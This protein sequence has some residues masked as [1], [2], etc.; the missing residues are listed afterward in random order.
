MDG[1]GTLPDRASEEQRLE[2]P[3]EV[4][5]LSE[6]V[7]GI[8][9][10]SR[11][12]FNLGQ[13]SRLEEIDQHMRFAKEILEDDLNGYDEVDGQFHRGQAQTKLIELLEHEMP[14]LVVIDWRT[15]PAG[16]DV[17]RTFELPTLEGALFMKVVTGD[18]PV[19]LS[20]QRANLAHSGDPLPANFEVSDAGTTYIL[21][22]FEEIPSDLSR[23]II[24]FTARGETNPRFWSGLS[25]ESPRSGQFSLRVEDENG[26]ATPTL[27]RIT[28]TSTGKLWAPPNAIDLWPTM[29]SVRG[30]PDTGSPQ[31]YMHYFMN[32]SLRGL[33]WIV[34]GPFEMPLPEGEWELYLIKGI[35]YTPVRT[36]F[37]VKAE[38]WT[39]EEIRLKRWV[40]M[41]AKGWYSGDDHVHARMMSSQDAS[42]I[43]AFVKAADIKVANILEMGDPGRTFYEQRGFGPAYRVVDDGYVLVPG[44]E[45]PRSDFG[46]AIGMNLTQL[47]R[48]LDKY[49]LN[50]WV[51]DEIHRQGGLYG[52]THVG[53]GGLG[54]HRDMTLLMPRGKSD[55]ASIM[56]NILGTGRYYDFLN[57][58]FK[59]AASAGSDTPYGGA[60]GITRVYAF[61]GQETPFSADA[62]FDAVKGGHT[63][64]TNGPMLELKVGE[65]MPGDTIV[66][67]QPG[68]VKIRARAW[69]LKEMSAPRSFS[70]VRNG[71]VVKKLHLEHPDQTELSVELDIETGN[72]CWIAVTAEGLDGSQAHTTPVYI[73]RKGFR[74]WNTDEADRLIKERFATLD[75]IEQLV[76]AQSDR[77]ANGTINPLEYG[78]ILIA[79]QAPEIMERTQLVRRLYQELVTELNKELDAGS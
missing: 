8:R 32:M 72:G 70:V 3:A 19:E 68:T 26:Q 24:T 74:H 77:M 51:A 39:R 49:M 54:I 45:D 75:E 59:L 13:L 12:Q 41:P 42:D 1:H 55:F 79:E 21:A 67:D 63:F 29:K 18:G 9:E 14:E 71:V 62:W 56:Q 50:D 5:G 57:L 43:M 31:P 2:I 28:N 7:T 15:G 37:T 66:L 40:D 76:Q 65:S 35:E 33:Y 6:F 36:T 38:E 46:H 30:F 44:Q 60:V 10:H 4:P 25:V 58:G 53:E 73:H 64:V 27:I 61:I 20:V 16:H 47:A 23:L 52:H 78:N 17:M 48:D 22:V 11:N 69:G 34:P